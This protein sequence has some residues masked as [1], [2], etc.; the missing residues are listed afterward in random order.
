MLLEVVNLHPPGELNFHD[1]IKL[2]LVDFGFKDGQNVNLMLLDEVT[3]PIVLKGQGETP[4]IPTSTNHRD[5]GGLKPFLITRW[6]I[7]APFFAS[8]WTP[9]CF[10][11]LVAI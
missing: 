6:G 1:P 3:Y 9:F 5:R 7:E 2:L 11:F 10:G 4:Y 8:A